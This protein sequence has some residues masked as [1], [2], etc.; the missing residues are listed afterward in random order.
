M[1]D[2]S[3]A[4]AVAVLES[5]LHADLQGHA[6]ALRHLEAW[7]AKIPFNAEIQYAKIGHLHTLGHFEDCLDCCVELIRR[8][9]RSFMSYALRARAEFALGMPREAQ[10][11]ISRAAQLNPGDPLV[12]ALLAQ[13]ERRLARQ[14]RIRSEVSRGPRR[15]VASG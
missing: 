13:I 10:R 5:D 11:S 4:D 15:V 2:L 14:H 3:A 6:T 8:G 12:D 9:R 1:I 7:Q